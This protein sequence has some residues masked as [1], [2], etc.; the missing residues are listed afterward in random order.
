LVGTMLSFSERET[1][2]GELTSSVRV[3]VCVCVYVCVCVCMCVCVC[4]CVCAYVCVCVCTPCDHTGKNE[5]L[6]PGEMPRQHVCYVQLPRHEKV[7]HEL[8]K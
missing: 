2:I 8:H 4:V 5:I 1:M 7:R 6:E 3:C